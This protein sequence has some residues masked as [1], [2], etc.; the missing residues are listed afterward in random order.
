MSIF[1]HQIITCMYRFKQIFRATLTIAVLTLTAVGCNQT[2][3]PQSAPVLDSLVVAQTT[4]L[5]NDTAKPSCKVDIRIIYPTQIGDNKQLD[6]LHTRMI[7][8]LYGEET[9]ATTFAD[10][11]DQ[12][13]KD[14]FADYRS[15][16]A[17]Y[18]KAL[19]AFGVEMLH[20]FNHS[21]QIELNVVYCADNIFSFQVFNSSFTGGAH[22]NYTY[23]NYTID[24]NTNTPIKQEDLFTEENMAQVNKMIY[25]KLRTYFGLTNEEKLEDAGVFNGNEVIGNDNILIDDKGITWLF[26]PYEIAPYAAGAPTAFISFRELSFFLKEKTPLPK[27]L[28]K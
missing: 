12:F 18:N 7:R 11:T 26:N 23:S 6:E 13:I 20:S 10:A 4:H 14:L 5:F 1:V 27:H 9:S 15:M 8:A 2:S 22:G 25:D 16:E 17:D 21:T 3:P 28:T 24:L 19:K